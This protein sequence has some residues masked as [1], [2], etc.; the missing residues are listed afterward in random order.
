MRPLQY[1]VVAYVTTTLGRFIEDL[2]REVHPEQAHLGAHLS[3]LP[4]RRLSGPEEAARTLLE[5]LCRDAQP[6]EVVLGEV[7]SFAPVTPTVFIQVAHGGYRMREL[8]DKLHTGVLQGEEQWPYMPHLTIA[9][10]AD[11]ARADQVR[12]V[13][14]RRWAEFAGSRRVLIEQLVFVREGENEHWVDVA[15]VRLGAQAVPSA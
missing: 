8:H 5:Q 13:A 1:A 14:E 7:E 4:P 12:Q 11:M 15:P 10:V 6:F 2:R 3:I 9:K